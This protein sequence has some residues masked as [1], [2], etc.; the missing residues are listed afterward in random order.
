MG[1]ASEDFFK[2]YFSAFLLACNQVGTVAIE[3]VIIQLRNY[4]VWW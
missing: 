2:I 1:R 4:E 3:L